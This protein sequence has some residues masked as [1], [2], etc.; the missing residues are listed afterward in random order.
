[1]QP[2]GDRAMPI[3]LPTLHFNTSPS[4]LSTG[5]IVLI[6]LTVPF[7]TFLSGLTIDKFL[8]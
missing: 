4:S 5:A 8:D 3:C 1:M 2:A 6:L 7:T